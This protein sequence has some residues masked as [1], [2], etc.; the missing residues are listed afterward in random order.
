MSP[1]LIKRSPGQ[2]SS[3]PLPN[4]TPFTKEEV[5]AK[6]DRKSTF[7]HNMMEAFP[8]PGKGTMK[9]YGA[10]RTKW[11]ERQLDIENKIPYVIEQNHLHYTAKVARLRNG[12]ERSKAARHLGFWQQLLDETRANHAQRSGL[13]TGDS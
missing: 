5:L 2:G 12:P 13:I 9:D 6:A 8:K 7:H 1:H 11:V 10:L 4:V 3:R